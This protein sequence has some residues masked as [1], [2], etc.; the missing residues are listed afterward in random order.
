VA[1]IGATGRM[2]EAIAR[3]VQ[4]EGGTPLLLARAPERLHALASA[5]QLDAT[6]LAVVDVTEPESLR[7][8]AAT[9]RNLGAIDHV[10]C[11]TGL[12]THQ[13]LGA[14]DDADIARAVQVDLLGPIQ[15]ARAFLPVITE[16][17]VIALF[18][19][20]ANGGVVL[21]YYTIDAAAR[22]G[23][24]GFCAAT[25]REI[26]LEGG[27]QLLCYTCPAPLDSAIERPYTSWWSKLGI[28]PVSA[29]S[30][31]NFVLG[32]LLARRTTAIMGWRALLLAWLHA[33]FPLLGHMLV[34]RAVERDA[35]EREAV[36]PEA[37]LE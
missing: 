34:V 3:A 22:S 35:R 12:L 21:P 20:F 1:V 36:P 5:L 23:L 2:G 13:P 18:G 17:G 10:V 31:A 4:R 9:L 32:S 25:N 16:R 14:H 37:K 27:E 6:Q 19:G 7:A 26:E 28:R 11:A 30:A 33:A 8:A 15:V 29:E 24:A